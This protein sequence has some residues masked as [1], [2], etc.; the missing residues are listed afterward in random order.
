MSNIDGKQ[1]RAQNT[2]QRNFF[3]AVLTV[4]FLNSN[5]YKLFATRQV[6]L[7][8]WRHIATGADFTEVSW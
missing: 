4:A 2:A 8:P 5:A 3:G 6:V 7:D 1:D